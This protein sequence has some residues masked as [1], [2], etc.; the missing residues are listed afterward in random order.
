LRWR[1]G[2]GAVV[3]AAGAFWCAVT[4]LLAPLARCSVGERRVQLHLETRAQRRHALATCGS[5]E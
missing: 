1:T 3:L 5:D 4:P 2:A